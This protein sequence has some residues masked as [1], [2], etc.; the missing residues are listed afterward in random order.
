MSSTES[1][2]TSASSTDHKALLSQLQEMGYPSAQ[3]EKAL[4]ATSTVEEALGWL[5]LHGDAAEASSSSSVVA[6]SIRCVDTGKLF[7]TMADAMIYAERTGHANF[8]ETDQVIPPMTE[9]E[10]KERVEKVKQL[11]KDKVANREL[12]EKKEALEREKKRRAG[13]QE[14]VKIREEQ[15][16][17]QLLFIVLAF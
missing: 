5:E 10:K 4:A 12:T 1:P 2:P 11:I 14:M 16:V 3:A 13:G 7:R 17:R 9:Q 15:E 8:E 6:K